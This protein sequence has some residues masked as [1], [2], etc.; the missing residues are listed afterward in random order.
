VRTGKDA[1]DGARALFDQRAAFLTPLRA[2]EADLEGSALDRF[3]SAFDALEL[4]ILVCRSLAN[5]WR[6]RVP[7]RMDAHSLDW[8]EIALMD[9][10]QAGILVASE[11]LALLRT[12]FSTGALARWRALHETTTKAEFISAGGSELLLHTAERYI[13]HE[14][15][16]GNQSLQLWKGLSKKL[17]VHDTG[18]RDFVTGITAEREAAIVAYGQ[19]FRT[20][21]GWAHDQLLVVS[22]E[23]AREYRSEKRPRGPS[24]DDLDRAVR[25]DDEDPHPLHWRYLNALANSAVHGSPRSHVTFNGGKAITRL[26]PHVDG[27]SQAGEA[28]ARRLKHLVWAF[29]HPDYGLE[30]SDRSEELL[31]TLAETIGHLAGMA[32]ST[33]ALCRLQRQA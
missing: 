24:F 27:S 16:R 26:G 13:Q 22:P 5:I 18:A 10:F 20:E 3:A 23:Y 8:G 6:P 25:R 17:G 2:Q 30:E 32:E 21:Y 28:T 29:A 11:V 1:H 33:F 19:M 14:E 9:L 7:D 12:G 31:P 15:F 4:A